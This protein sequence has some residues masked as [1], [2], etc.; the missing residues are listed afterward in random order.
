MLHSNKNNINN[1]KRKNTPRTSTMKLHWA[2]LMMFTTLVC[3]P[4]CC[5]TALIRII[6]STMRV[7]RSDL[8]RRLRKITGAKCLKTAKRWLRLWY[9]TNDEW[10]LASRKYSTTHGSA[11]SMTCLR[12]VIRKQINHDAQIEVP[13]AERKISAEAIGDGQREKRVENKIFNISIQI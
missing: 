6:L 8:T 12:S 7:W 5:L 11:I 3:S 10:G 4:S 9:Q 2:W 13:E 1:L